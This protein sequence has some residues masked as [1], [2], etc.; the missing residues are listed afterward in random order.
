MTS[1]RYCSQMETWIQAKILRATGMR[2]QGLI[3]LPSPFTRE[4]RAPA[5]PNEPP[6][7]MRGK[8]PIEDKQRIYLTWRSFT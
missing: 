1:P 3:P 7:E 8:G 6:S 2:R 5:E 4:G